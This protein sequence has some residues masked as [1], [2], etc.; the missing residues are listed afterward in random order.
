MFLFRKKGD[1]DDK[2]KTPHKKNEKKKKPFE[3][4]DAKRSDVKA[5]G[6]KLPLMANAL[7]FR[8]GSIYKSQFA[9]TGTFT[10]FLQSTKPIK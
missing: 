4:P 7:D 1:R 5:S 6:A 9:T 10:T 8:R 3:T 2:E